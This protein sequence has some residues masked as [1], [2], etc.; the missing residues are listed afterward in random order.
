MTMRL[1][2]L[3]ICIAAWL[4]LHADNMQPDSLRVSLVTCDAGPEIFELYGH[5][6]V[7]VTGTIQGYPIDVVYNYGMFDFDSPGFIYRFVKGDTDYYAAAIPTQAFLYSYAL[8]GS[9]VTEYPLQLSSDEAKRLVE[10]LN[11]DITPD[12]RTYRYKYF[13]NNCSTRILD[14]LDHVLGAPATYPADTESYE[15]K[16]YRDLLEHYNS[17]YPWYQLGIDIALGAYI[18]KEISSR[19]RMFAPLSLAGTISLARRADGTLLTGTPVTLEEGSGDVRLAPTP[20]YLSP[21]FLFWIIGIIISSATLYRH[22]H[23]KRCKLILASWGLIIGLAGILLWFL[24]FISEHE[25]TSPNALAIW[26]NPFWLIVPVMVWSQ[27][28]RSTLRILL[29]LQGLAALA[30]PAAASLLHQHINHALYPLLLTSI[31]LCATGVFPRISSDT[32][33]NPQKSA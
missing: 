24:V 3:L 20:W 21:I 2:C 27:K 17:G 14:N 23:H 16:S 31:V 9:R 8:R 29:T 18:D 7:R 11:H 30:T 1:Y 5:E 32:K 4:G 12:Y 28:M 10:I 19:E 33:T 22:A 25:G 26:L 13:S 15:Y 6:A